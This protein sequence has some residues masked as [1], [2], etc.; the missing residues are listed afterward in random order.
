MN[1]NLYNDLNKNISFARVHTE[2]LMQPNQLNPQGTIHGG[3]IMKIVDTVAGMVGRKHCKGTL[4]TRRLDDI[5]FH[6]PI[7]VGEIITVIGQLIYVG[8][9]SMEIVVQVY[10]HDLNDFSNPKLAVSSFVTMVHLV[11]WTPAKVPELVVNSKE[12]KILYEIGEKKHKE[13]RQKFNK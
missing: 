11:D 5:E 12:D 6:K 2:M 1:Y 10:V 7:K 13:I 4:V 3:E 9:S 8:T